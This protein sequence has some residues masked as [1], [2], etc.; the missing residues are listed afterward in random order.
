[1]ELRK[2][3]LD[4]WDRK[5]ADTQFNLGLTYLSSSSD[6]QKETANTSEDGSSHE[7]DGTPKVNPAVLAKEHCEKGIA[8]HVECAKTFGGIL[9]QL[10]GVEPETLL[11]EVSTAKPAAAGFKTTGLDDDIVS[12]AVASQTLNILRKAA[13]SLVASNPPTDTAAANSVYDIQQVLDE[14]QETVDEAERAMDAVRQASAIKVQAQKQAAAL[15]GPADGTVVSTSEDGVTTSI[16]FGAASAAAASA[17]PSSSAKQTMMV[18]KKKKKRSAEGTEEDSKP[19]AAVP[20]AK[21]AKT[22]E[23]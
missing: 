11:S 8:A 13:T 22:D 16:G 17:T 14:I 6:L 9:A 15:N 3:Y 4:R 21:R 12:A 18:V 5:I 19:V 20:D 10:C 2:I 1:L 7:H 23:E